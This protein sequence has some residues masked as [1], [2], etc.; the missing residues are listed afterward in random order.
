MCELI[1]KMESTLGYKSHFSSANDN[2]DTKCWELLDLGKTTSPVEAHPCSHLTSVVLVPNARV[3]Q[4]P[5]CVYTPAITQGARSMKICFYRSLYSPGLYISNKL[6]V[7]LMLWVLGSHSQQQ[8]SICSLNSKDPC[9][10]NNQRVRPQDTR[11]L[12]HHPGLCILLFAAVCSTRL[13]IR[14]TI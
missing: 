8:D 1:K 12:I 3:S 11:E 10:I 2:G 7:L 5:S 9:S 14:Q 13:L 4:P 6:Q